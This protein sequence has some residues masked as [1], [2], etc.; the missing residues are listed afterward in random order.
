MLTI[1]THLV[2]VLLIRQNTLFPKSGCTADE[3]LA[4]CNFRGRIVTVDAVVCLL[5]HHVC[6]LQ[7]VL[8]DNEKLEAAINGT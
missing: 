2:K 7:K 3:L 5:K 8:A 6:V 1:D 4:H